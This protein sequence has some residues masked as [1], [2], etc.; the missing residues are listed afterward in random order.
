M[1]HLGVC[2][3]ESNMRVPYGQLGGIERQTCLVC[4]ADV[5]K[6]SPGC[7]CAA[8]FLNDM[9]EKMEERKVRIVVILGSK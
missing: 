2:C 7:G 6:L 3:G 1:S 4:L 9:Q 8:Q 5:E